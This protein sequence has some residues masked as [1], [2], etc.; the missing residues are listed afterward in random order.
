MRQPA[1]AAKIL[2]AG[3]VYCDLIFSG[4]P[5]MPVL[6]TEIFAGD[7]NLHAGGGS[8]I[9]AAYLSAL[10][11]R[12]ALTAMLPAEPFGSLVTAEIR[13]MGLDDR[14]CQPAPVGLEPQITV[15]MVRN[16]ERAFLTRRASTALPPDT[17]GSFADPDLVHLHIGELTTLIE[18]PDLIRL[19]RSSGLSISLD[20]G[21]DEAA[22]AHP[23][24]SAL[25]SA[26]DV[27]LPNAAE[28]ARLAAHGIDTR[29]APFTIIKRGAQ[30][31]ELYSRG[32]RYRRAGRSV[33]VVDT[34]GAGDAFNAGFLTAWLEGLGPDECLDAGNVAGSVAVGRIGGA[35]GLSPMTFLKT[36]AEAEIYL[37]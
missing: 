24:L 2:C 8:Y 30:G 6:G 31:A 12:V 20:C 35:S 32:Q 25:I 26:V 14:F 5:S 19:A 17:A 36:G 16:E 33:D 11:N 22:F 21:W 15:A 10:G 28:A 9:T 1:R 29:I 4:L 34:T 27:F 13:H 3:R 18:H 7:V 23:G 37:S